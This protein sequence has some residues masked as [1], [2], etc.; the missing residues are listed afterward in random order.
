MTLADAVHGLAALAE[1]KVKPP[2]VVQAARL[3]VQLQL[4]QAL[5]VEIQ[6][7]LL[8]EIVGEGAKSID[9]THPR[10]NEFAKEIETAGSEPFVAEVKPLTEDMLSDANTN[11]IAVATLL[12]VGLLT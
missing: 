12:R 9:Q 5:F 2:H 11:H 4:A 1:V 8:G 7:R 3:I 6:K 10:F